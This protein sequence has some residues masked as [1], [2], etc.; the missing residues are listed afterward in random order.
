MTDGLIATNLITKPLCCPHTL[1]EVRHFEACA[2]ANRCGHGP[3]GDESSS[4]MP[5]LWASTETG[6]RLGNLVWS[7]ELAFLLLLSQRFY[8][9]ARSDHSKYCG[10]ISLGLTLPPR[11]RFHPGLTCMPYA[12]QFSFCPLP[13]GLRCAPSLLRISW[14]QEA[15]QPSTRPERVF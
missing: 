13:E 9:A 2:E 1:P 12:S 11:E 8:S 10:F 4:E 3:S 6:L 7:W 15:P 5:W 14:R